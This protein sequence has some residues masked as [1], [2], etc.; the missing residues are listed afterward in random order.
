MGI[1]L[2]FGSNLKYY[3]KQKNLSQEELAAKVD[4]G[5]KHLSALE[6]GTTFVSADLLERIVC[7]LG[8][9]ASALFYTPEEKSGDDGMLTFV[10]KIVETELQKTVEAIK[11]H[12]R[13]T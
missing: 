8:V 12:I 2:I 5:P 1:K 9:S 4:V 11:V 10:D 7:V 6:R 13:Q 3:R